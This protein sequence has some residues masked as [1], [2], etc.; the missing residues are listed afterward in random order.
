VSISVLEGPRSVS[1]CGCQCPNSI[2][3]RLA[4]WACDSEQ[5]ELAQSKSRLERTV[6]EFLALPEEE[7]LDIARDIVRKL[8]KGKGKKAAM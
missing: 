6:E 3:T 8:V 4:Y 2:Y 1:A 5:A 7:K